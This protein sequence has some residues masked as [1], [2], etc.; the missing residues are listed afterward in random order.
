MRSILR[1]LWVLTK[2]LSQRLPRWWQVLLLL[3]LLAVVGWKTRVFAEVALVV[4]T[5]GA[6]FLYG[7]IGLL[8]DYRPKVSIRSAE[9]LCAEVEKS[10]REYCLILRPFG[11]DG[12]ILTVKAEAIRNPKRVRGDTVVVEE[13]VDRA[14][15]AV[16]NLDAWT[17][18][19]PNAFVLPPGPKW[20]RSDNASWRGYIKRLI[21]RALV[22]IIVLPPSKTRT[23]SLTWEVEQC[24]ANGLVGRMLFVL[25]PTEIAG[26][27]S[28]RQCVR[29]FSTLFPLLADL[30]DTTVAVW[31]KNYEEVEFW[32]EI[33][34]DPDELKLVGK[35]EAFVTDEC[36][37]DILERALGAIRS[38]V[39]SA[40]FH[41]RYA[42]AKL[43]QPS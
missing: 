32:H 21:K 13:L 25:P 22:V 42:Y 20:V 11:A 7:A 16:F 15:R 39:G 5:T 35:R 3:L 18:V 9:D 24:V 1:R 2:L 38:E 28:S 26:S 43:Q 31:P 29:E 23:L 17:L 4:I 12:T 6:L 41:Q 10:R 40:P 33:P 37:L 8:L 19:D 34:I 27:D 14:S 30:P 36:Y